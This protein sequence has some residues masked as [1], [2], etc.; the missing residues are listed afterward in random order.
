[1][2]KSTTKRRKTAP[3]TSARQKPAV[4]PLIRKQPQSGQA[5]AAKSA[6]CLH[7]DD[8][9]SLAYFDPNDLHSLERELFGGHKVSP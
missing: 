4:E 5:V 3:N 8:A 2:K 7:T 9:W 1:M 6:M